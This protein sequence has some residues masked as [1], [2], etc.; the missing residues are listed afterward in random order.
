MGLFQNLST[1]RVMLPGQYFTKCGL[2]M[3]RVDRI[4]AGQNFKQV[5]NRVIE[6]TIIHVIPSDTPETPHS[7]GDSCAVVLSSTSLYSASTW[8]NFLTSLTGFKQADLDLPQVRQAF[9]NRDS[10]DWASNEDPAKGDVQPLRGWVGVV[11]VHNKAMG[12][13]NTGKPEKWLKVP[14]FERG[15]TRDELTKTLNQESLARY[16][17][18]NTLSL[19]L[20]TYPLVP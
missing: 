11:R 12:G 2:Y 6:T 7:V 20:P 9:G 3:F 8:V 10:D 18:G 16:F 1:T 14:V 15:V 13:G 17:P 5:A 4:K 19:V